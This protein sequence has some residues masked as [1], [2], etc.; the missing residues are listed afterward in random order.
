MTAVGKKGAREL[1]A[2]DPRASG[3]RAR[4]RR[5]GNAFALGTLRTVRGT[6]KRFIALAVI[7]LLGVTMIVG[8]RAAC[9]DLRQSADEF[10]DAQ[11]LFDV[12]V[13]STLGL[14][15][16][17]VAA[18]AGT[19]GVERAE[20]G[21]TETVYT[22]VGSGSS[23]A[24][25]RALSDDGLNEPRVLEGELP[26][27]ADEV[28]VTRRYAAE[29]GVGVGDAVTFRSAADSDSQSSKEGDD[30]QKDAA[31]SDS[32]SDELSIDLDDDSADAESEPIFARK[33]Y[34]IS[35]IVLDPQ[36]INAGEGTMSFRASGGAQY[37]FF[38]TK[39]NVQA[40]VY[41]VAYLSVEGA[42]V[43]LCYSDEYERLVSDVKKRVDDAREE[44]QRARGES[45]R[46]DANATIDDAED[47]ANAKL[48]DGQREI[49]DAQAELD[50]GRAQLEDGKEQLTL[51]E[52]LAVRQMDDAQAQIS[53]GLAQLN[54]KAVE[55]DA[56]EP[57]V[58]DGIAQVEGGIRQIEDGIRQLDEGIATAGSD[59]TRAAAVTQAEQAAADEVAKKFAE[60]RSQVPDYEHI[61]DNVTALEAGV[62]Q[63][64]AALEQLKQMDPPAPEEQLQ[65]AEAQV[66][67]LQEQLTQLKAA[68]E[69]LSP[70]AEETATAQAKQQAADAADKAIDDKVAELSQTKSGLESQLADLTGK[71]DQLFS[72]RAQ[73]EAGRAQIASARAQLA[74][75]QAT[76]NANRAKALAQISDARATLRQKEGELNDGAAQL[77]DARATLE[78]KRS[79]AAQ[80]IAD[81]RAKVADIDDPTWYVQDRGSLSSYSSVESDASCIEVLGTVLPIVFFVVA[82]LISLTTMTR[83]VEEER[84]LIG[85]YKA[86]GYPRGRILSKYVAYAGSACLIGGIIGDFVGFIVLPAII[87]TI[88]STMYALPAFTYHLDAVYA[89][90]AIV[91]FMLGIV[92]ATATTC[93]KELRESPASLMRPKAPKAGSRILLERIRPVW[94]RL[95]FLNKVTARNIFRY[96]RRFLMTVFGIAGCVALLICGFGIRDTVLSLPERQYG[97]DGGAIR[98]DLVAASSTSD[99]DAVADDLGVR[100]EVRDL[101]RVR[102]DQLTVSY[103]DTSESVTLY[104]F[105]DGVDA[106]RYVG[107]GDASGAEVALDD[108][109]CAITK[110]AEQVLGFGAGDIVH[111]QDPTLAES[112]VEVNGV[113]TNYLGNSMYMS[114]SAYERCFAKKCEQNGLL[115]DLNGDSAA[116]IDFADGLTGDERLLS[117]TSTA[118]L[119]RDFSSAFT[120]INTVVYV[121]IVL[122]AALSF[123]VVFTLSNTNISERERELAT[124]KVLGFKHG[125][126][127]VY[128]NKETI[129]LTGIGI[130]AGLPLGYA[131]TRSLTLVLKMPS[132]YFDTVVA[133][134]T[135][136]IAAALAFAF[137][138][139]VNAMTNRSLDR[140]DMVGALK[141]AE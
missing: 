20:G 66:A 78:S 67:Q 133:W 102:I 17:D 26:T 84:G 75:A 69:Q 60:G 31:G 121:V 55:I 85:L 95:S 100:E 127:H 27:S 16:D 105:P 140:V 112:N 50:D 93:V 62:A 28:A 57:Q 106:S 14:T 18:L 123:T 8:L 48:A 87:F 135:Y 5:V 6:L 130:V 21:W 71:R 82:I 125:E 114:E 36:D 97:K 92:G 141:S 19:E 137:T 44:R 138:L 15:D 25:V 42:E 77:A 110:S 86:L 51:Q 90:A 45:V 139:M 23:K 40:D 65:Q 101:Q 115:A 73:L 94:S 129:I 79:E 3:P 120:L 64:T 131:L 72:A 70:E 118:K 98:Y 128:I 32:S 80:K 41:T 58:Q 136:L 30:A 13:Q 88:F 29:T 81:A 124:I 68:K 96:K 2:N 39:D 83:M 117:V 11:H 99:L 122:A 61:D 52:A 126:V 22:T 54:Q 38:V 111:V 37:A 89:V 91:L 59:Q 134:P 104:V 47:E 107:L 74:D 24:E 12:R 9:L 103:G 34:R 116:Q 113:V 56:N 4:K 53:A 35:A 76:L 49:D 108:S 1:R 119:V 33:E 43:P 132:L 63:A 109:G 10:F 7:C 46:A